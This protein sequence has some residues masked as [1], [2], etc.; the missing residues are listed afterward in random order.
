MNKQG[1]DDFA[2][3]HTFLLSSIHFMNN[4]MASTTTSK[5][6]RF[7]GVETVLLR[8]RK[9]QQYEEHG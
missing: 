9:Q 8:M 7:N 2:I 5:I 1:T 4:S 6:I 3:T